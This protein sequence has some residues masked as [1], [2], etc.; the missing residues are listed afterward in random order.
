LRPGGRFVA[1]DLFAAGGLAVLMQRLLELGLLHGE[2]R[3]VDGR[4][5]TEIAAAAVE[6][7]GQ[8]VIRP[9]SRPLSAGGGIAILRGNLAPDG[10]VL[11]LAGHER[12]Q[13]RGPARVFDT[14]E[15]AFDAVRAGVVRA[16]DV[17]VIR[18]E[19]P[20]G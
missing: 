16:G 6:T 13:H 10:C 5:A 4:R 18:Y 15:A 9:A 7:A 19:G 17:V 1:G 11:K 12:A 2:A 20:V 14:E 3:N 8:E